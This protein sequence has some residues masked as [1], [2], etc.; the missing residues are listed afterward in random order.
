MTE[1]SEY[2]IQRNFRQLFPKPTT[3]LT[4]Q[5]PYG[6]GYSN[7]DLSM[8]RKTE[9]LKYNTPSTSGA[10]T[11][12]LTR[13]ERFSQIARGFSPQQKTVRNATSEQLAFCDSSMN[14]TL[15]NKANIPGPA[16]PLY[17]DKNVPLY[18][19]TQPDRNFNDNVDESESI[20]AFYPTSNEILNDSGTTITFEKNVR[21]Q[22]GVLHIIR[23]DFESTLSFILKLVIDT[24]SIPVLQVSVNGSLIQQ[25]TNYQYTISSA[26]GSGT[27]DLTISN[28]LI[29]SDQ[30]YYFVFS[31]SF[32][33]KI[34]VNT[35][36]ILMNLV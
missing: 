27:Y 16:I 23:N 1:N 11:N 8:R 21:T 4:L 7:F 31:L 17:E 29:P 20:F 12:T 3:R 32:N 26:N 24:V 5:S 25:T 2:C 33:S 13:R 34:L 10:K 19:F 18:M 35:E 36:S 22:L 6:Q 30:P 14:T 9:I 28:I 15:S